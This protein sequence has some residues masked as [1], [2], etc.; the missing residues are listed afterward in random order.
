VSRVVGPFDETTA[1]AGLRR[2]HRVPDRTWG[3]LR[4]LSGTI[5]FSMDVDPPIDR[6]LTT[7]DEQPIPPQVAHEVRVT[8][9]VV[10]EVEFLIRP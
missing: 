6:R 4:V 10:F 8:D 3:R 1:P 5:G 9:P 2:S 7:G